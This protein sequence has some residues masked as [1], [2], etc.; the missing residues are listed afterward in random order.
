MERLTKRVGCGEA[1]PV[2]EGNICAPFEKAGLCKTG[3]QGGVFGRWERHCNDTCVLGTII[4]KL[5]AYEDSGLTPEEVASMARLKATGKLKLMPC[6]IGDTVYEI[7]IKYTKK[8][9]GRGKAYD[10]SCIGHPGSLKYDP[11]SCYVAPKICT[12]TDLL[13]IGKMV[14]TTEQEAIEVLEEAKRSAKCHANE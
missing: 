1:V 5:A 12:K 6:A 14:Y 10:Y 11:A 13:H 8:L 3:T 9:K 7:R 2:A 4:D